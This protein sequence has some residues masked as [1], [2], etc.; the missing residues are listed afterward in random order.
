VVKDADRVA[1]GEPVRLED[2]V[3][4]YWAGQAPAYLRSQTQ[5]G[6]LL[7]RNLAPGQ[8]PLAWV[9]TRK[10]GTVP[11]Y[12][13]G[14]AVKMRPL[15]SAIK[16][17]RER[18]RTCPV[19][20]VLRSY[21][22]WQQCR[23]CERAEQVV[24]ARL[25]QR[26]CCGCRTV[27]KTPYPK[28]SRQLCRVCLVARTARRREAELRMLVC[29]GPDCTTA[30]AT[31]AEVRRWKKANPH[32]YWQ[33]RMC[34]VCTEAEAERRAERQRE[35]E[36]RAR[37]ARERR[38]RE[39][40]ELAAWAREALDDPRTVV[41]DTETTG[42]DDDARIVE[43][44]IITGS[45]EVLVDTLLN[46]GGEPIP[47]EAASIHG[48]TD[49]MVTAE[50]VPSFSEVL[51]RLT[52]ALDGRRCLI[53]NAAFDVARL[54]H[55]LRLH[56]L[57]RAAKTA[58]DTA[59]ATGSLAGVP[60]RDELVAGALARAASWLDGMTWEDVM[61]PYSD[62]YGDWNEYFGNYAWQPLN[63]GHRA[64][65]DCRKVLKRLRQMANSREFALPAQSCAELEVV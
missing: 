37:A 1:R 40:A 34:P 17:R 42:L 62:W 44:S 45:G 20:G 46:P 41:L 6:G 53:Y 25:W 60:P 43:I 38:E 33:H 28:G 13:P 22:V 15:P 35:A 48:I 49:A 65:G 24:R 18:E 11:L 56:Y 27:R 23:T 39:V 29:S 61:I 8:Q 30:V 52:V 19:C 9:E 55:E 26:T 57:D 16:L 47:D 63:G 50:G 21:R 58:A 64:L 3:P 4:V 59:A 51:D 36:E 54:R 5:L 2:G 31:R 7:R 12:D 32:G 10:W 14:A